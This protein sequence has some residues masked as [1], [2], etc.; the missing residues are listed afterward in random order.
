MVTV[1]HGEA[2]AEKTAVMDFDVIQEDFIDVSTGK[3]IDKHL[4]PVVNLFSEIRA[5][6]QRQANYREEKADVQRKKNETCTPEEFLKFEV[7]EKKIGKALKYLSYAIKAL[8]SAGHWI[9]D[10][11]MTYL[12]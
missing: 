6:E 11:E 7:R 2:G 1:K 12:S 4:P 3:P 5:L 10:S 8:E 9:A